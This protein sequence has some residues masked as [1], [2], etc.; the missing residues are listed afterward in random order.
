MCNPAYIEPTLDEIPE[1]LNPLIEDVEDISSEGED[2]E[3]YE[4]MSAMSETL[5]PSATDKIEVTV[6]EFEKYYLEEFGHLHPQYDGVAD[7]W[8]TPDDQSTFEIYRYLHL[9]VPR[10]D[11]LIAYN[12]GVVQSPYDDFRVHNL[13]YQPENTAGY[14]CSN[15]AAYEYH[16]E[17][18]AHAWFDSHHGFMV[19][20]KNYPMYWF[21]ARCNGFLYNISDCISCDIC[22]HTEKN[23]LP[24]MEV[25]SVPS[26]HVDG[27]GHVLMIPSFALL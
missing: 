7:V 10:R 1:Y 24:S 3:A 27:N 8:E 2:L 17:F 12:A 16:S 22:E 20:V 15:C 23:E 21:C 18:K 9:S 26:S 5:F 6:F 4:S 14:I 11:F 25:I 19:S 13:V